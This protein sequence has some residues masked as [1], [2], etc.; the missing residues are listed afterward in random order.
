[1]LKTILLV[2]KAIEPALAVLKKGG[3]ITLL[4]A[5]VVG[6]VIFIAQRMKQR[7]GTAEA[8]ETPIDVPTPT[9]A[10]QPTPPQPNV[11]VAISP[12]LETLLTL[13][14]SQQISFLQTKTLKEIA[15]IQRFLADLPLVQ[16]IPIKGAIREVFRRLEHV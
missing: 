14:E 3:W 12:G 16:Q 2:L 7:H 6:I 10:L 4:I 13:E 5:V 9:T 1:M 11:E 15:Q 8:Q